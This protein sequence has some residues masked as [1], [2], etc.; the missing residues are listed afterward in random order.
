MVLGG[1]WCTTGA[2]LGL[3]V[4][5]ASTSRCPEQENLVLENTFFGVKFQFFGEKLVLKIHFWGFRMHFL[6]FGNFDQT[7]WGFP[8]SCQGSMEV[9][10]S[11]MCVFLFPPCTKTGQTFKANQGI[12]KQII[13]FQTV[14]GFVLSSIFTWQLYTQAQGRKNDRHRVSALCRVWHGFEWALPTW[15]CI[16][17]FRKIKNHPNAHQRRH[18]AV[19]I[20][21]NHSTLQNPSKP[22]Q[23]FPNPPNPQKSSPI[24]P[25]HQKSPETFPKPK[26]PPQPPQNHPPNPP[27]HPQTSPHPPQTRQNTSQILRNHPIRQIS[28]QN[29]TPLSANFSTAFGKFGT[30][31]EPVGKIR[32]PPQKA[33]KCL[34]LQGFGTFLVDFW[35]KPCKKCQIRPNKCQ[36]PAKT[37]IFVPFGAVHGFSRLVPDWF[38]ICRKRCQISIFWVSKKRAVSG[39]NRLKPDQTLPNL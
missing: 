12:S 7:S 14:L 31:R 26:P 9:V 20:T 6:G 36:I 8:W 17:T 30:S 32:A 33:Q 18:I 24:F 29:L 22:L 34:F 3:A 39:W 37:S 5:C 28:G 13:V 4:F 11:T 19:K 21:R 27:E 25:N 38:R 23:I 2:N 1:G 16:S 15:Q 35:Q 10:K